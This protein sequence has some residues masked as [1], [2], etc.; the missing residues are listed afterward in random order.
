M[1]PREPPRREVLDATDHGTHQTWELDCGHE[2]RV[3]N[4]VEPRPIPCI[5]CEEET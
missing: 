4:R 1:T 2:I 5:V 3:L